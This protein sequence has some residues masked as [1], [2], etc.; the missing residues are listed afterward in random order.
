MAFLEKFLSESV[1]LSLP[2]TVAK[3]KG[4]AVVSWNPIVAIISLLTSLE[5]LMRNPRTQPKSTPRTMC[6]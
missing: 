6:T 3:T 4:M 1:A 2:R 5:D